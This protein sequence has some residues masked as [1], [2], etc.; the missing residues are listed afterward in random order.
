VTRAYVPLLLVLA[1]IWGASYLFIKVAVRDLEPAVMTSARMLIA[2]P[3]LIGFLAVRGGPRTALSQVAGAWRPGLVYGVVNGAL[4]FT[5]IAW[6]EQ[7]VDSG[8]A[9]IANASVP[10][11]VAILAIWFKP[12][13]RSTGLRLAGIVLGRPG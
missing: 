1:A 4:P 8:V 11:F 6:G 7:H 3:L 13:E 10:I 12:S 5:L 9:A 2:A